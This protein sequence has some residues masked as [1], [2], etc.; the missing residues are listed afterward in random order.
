MRQLARELG[1]GLLAL[2]CILAL[3]AL[4]NMALP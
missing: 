2:G 4:V 1:L 3:I